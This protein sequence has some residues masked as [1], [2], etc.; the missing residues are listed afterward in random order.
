MKS[1]RSED[2][3][4]KPGINAALF[5]SLFSLNLMPGN[6]NQGAKARRGV[7]SIPQEL[8]VLEK[9]ESRQQIIA[10][11]GQLEKHEK[12]RIFCLEHKTKLVNTIVKM[13]YRYVEDKDVLF[14]LREKEP[15]QLNNSLNISDIERSLDEEFVT[16]HDANYPKR[17]NRE[18]NLAEK[19]GHGMKQET[20]Q[21]SACLRRCKHVRQSYISFPP[22]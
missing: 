14:R 10:W 18:F 22:S 9:P 19:V 17:K 15:H 6:D 13:Y 3:R 2:G 5:G 16:V 11:I 1:Q 8:F 7:T 4:D 20:M 12:Y 21:Y